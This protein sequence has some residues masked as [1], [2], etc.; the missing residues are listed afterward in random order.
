MTAESVIGCEYK[1]GEVDEENCAGWNDYTG[2]NFDRM[3]NLRKTRLLLKV[4]LRR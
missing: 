3:Y 2:G 4:Y 1:E